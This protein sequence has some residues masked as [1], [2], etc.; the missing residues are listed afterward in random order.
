MAALFSKGGN[1][2]ESALKRIKSFL[3]AEFELSMDCRET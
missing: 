2:K 1:I 3:D